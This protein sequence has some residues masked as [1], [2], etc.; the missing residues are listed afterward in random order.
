MTRLTRHRARIRRTKWIELSCLLCGESAAT[1][2]GGSVLRPRAANSVRVTDARVMC[3][4]CGGSLSPAPRTTAVAWQGG[5]RPF[6]DDDA[7]PLWVIE[8]ERPDS[9]HKID[10]AMAGA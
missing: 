2:D 5:R 8:K 9:P 3:V 6:R 10:A 7:K 4:R 1:L